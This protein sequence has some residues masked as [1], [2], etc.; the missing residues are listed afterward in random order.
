MYTITD[1]MKN[2][3]SERRNERTHAH[4]KARN[5]TNGNKLPPVHLDK[6]RRDKRESARRRTR[7]AAAVIVCHNAILSQ[8]TN[9]AHGSGSGSTTEAEAPRPRK[10]TTLPLLFSWERVFSERRA[11]ATFF[12]HPILF[13]L[14]FPAYCPTLSSSLM[15]GM[16]DAPEVLRRDWCY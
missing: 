11:L 16:G 5:G 3:R 4:G 7:R 6:A 2:R 1:G 13:T 15:G 9:H 8:P 12:Y 10:D 14:S